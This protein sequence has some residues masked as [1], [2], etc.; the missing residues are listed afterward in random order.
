MDDIDKEVIA[1]KAAM[2]KILDDR[3][4]IHAPCENAYK[5]GRDG[6]CFCAC[7]RCRGR[8]TRHWR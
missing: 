1:L 3:R 8:E 2:D 7:W 4:S 6:L 5:D